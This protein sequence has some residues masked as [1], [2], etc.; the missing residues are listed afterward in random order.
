MRPPAPMWAADMSP[1]AAAPSGP[2]AVKAYVAAKRGIRVIAFTDHSVSLG[3]ARGLSMDDH[4]RQQAEIEQ[5]RR[6]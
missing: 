3:V 1:S 5:V 2:H 6:Q 4:K